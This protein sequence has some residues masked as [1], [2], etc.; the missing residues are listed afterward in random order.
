MSDHNPVFALPTQEELGLKWKCYFQKAFLPFEPQ[1]YSIH[2]STATSAEE[3]RLENQLQESIL[4]L[5]ALDMAAS[6][7]RT[8]GSS[9]DLD[10]AGS[11]FNQGTGIPKFTEIVLFGLKDSEVLKGP[12]DYEAWKRR[13]MDSL[14]VY[15]LTKIIDKSVSRPEKGTSGRTNWKHA[16]IMVGKWLRRCMDPNLVQQ[17]ETIYQRAGLQWADDVFEAIERHMDA[18]GFGIDCQMATEFLDL[19]L[20]KFASTRDYVIEILRR[21][22]EMNDKGLVYSPYHLWA[23]IVGQI[24]KR[25]PEIAA[26]AI[27]TV[28]FNE[29]GPHNFRELDLHTVVNDL[30]KQL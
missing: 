26:A 17:V 2:P 25:H 1:Q 23:I 21:R 28:K 8:Y 14:M 3:N 5:Q 19:T 10:Q 24:Q 20:E 22:G 12:D 13:I 29:K 15:Q 18:Q 6:S 27:Q 16:S 4:R 11:D 9:M 30:L 7:E